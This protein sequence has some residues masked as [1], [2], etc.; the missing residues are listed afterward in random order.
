MQRLRGLVALLGSSEEFRGLVGEVATI[1][2]D[3]F[4][5]AAS[6]VAST[7]EQAADKARES[8]PSKLAQ[9][10]MSSRAVKEKGTAMSESAK[11]GAYQF[12]DEMESYL[13]EKFPKQRRDAVVNRL[14]K[15]IT[16][17]QENPEYQETVDFVVE[18]MK[19]YVKK[20]KEVAEE[21][22]DKDGGVKAKTDEHW[23]IAVK[24]IQ[25]LL[26]AFANG[27]PLD[28]IN[29]ALRKVVDDIQSDKDLKEFYDQ[30][31][32]EFNRLLTQKDY[33]TSDAADNRAHELYNRSQ[34]LLNEKQDRYRPDVENLFTELRAFIDAIR[35]DRESLRLVKA[36]KKVYSDIVR[37]DKYGNFRGFKKRIIW[38]IIEVIFPKFIDEIK[39]IPIPRIEYQDRDYDLILENVVL[40]SE[41]FLP[42]RTILEA[43]TRI[44][45]HNS[46][47]VSSS[48][49]TTTHLHV[50]N[51][52]LFVR[53]AS[54]IVRKKTGVIPFND[55]GYI[56]VFMTGRGASADIVLESVPSDDD[57]TNENY[58]HVKSVDVSIHSLT[59]NYHAYH[60]WAASL[61][62]PFIKPA[63]KKMVTNILEGKIKAAVEMADREIYAAA[64]RMR[65]AS[66][67]NRGGGSVEAW[68]RAVLSRPP[69]ARRSSLMRGEFRMNIDEPQLFPGEHAPGSILAKMKR[70]ED[71]VEAGMEQGGWRNQVFSIDA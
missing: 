47:T 70:A 59:Y 50:S 58:F 6:S 49:T 40:E 3:L 12:R 13:R 55:R 68:I 14:K 71:R 69:S 29:D 11:K 25:A 23:D 54:F 38:D 39:Y 33:V 52:N 48:H 44:E 64:E 60:T 30:V 19:G 28:P 36:S 62:S 53:D 66:I 45:I 8:D 7:A 10:E 43:F 65:V 22:I 21:V 35:N 2:R 63:I 1:G 26:M 18:V 42:T 67:A 4:A 20:V 5:D 24:D 56:D 51:I 32:E 37:T 41:H 16:D 9:G 15:V 61:L 57:D 17:I 34:E 27:K 46:Y 31:S